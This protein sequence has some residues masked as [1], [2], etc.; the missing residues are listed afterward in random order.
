M[1]SKFQ[2]TYLSKSTASHL[3]NFRRKTLHCLYKRT[4][5]YLTRISSAVVCL[6]LRFKPVTKH[7]FILTYP[8]EVIIFLFSHTKDLQDRKNNHTIFFF[9][10]ELCQFQFHIYISVS[11]SSLS[12]FCYSRVPDTPLVEK[13]VLI[14]AMGQSSVFIF[15]YL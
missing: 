8:M 12:L 10:L 13:K 5:P 3:L 15:S 9:I 6:L 1:R 7:H 11:Y 14:E 2:T 4:C